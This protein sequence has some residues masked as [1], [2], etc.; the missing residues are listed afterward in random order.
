LILKITLF[1]AY[2]FSPLKKINKK[3][4]ITRS[5]NNKATEERMREQIIFQ[6]AMAQIDLEATL[7]SIRSYFL[8]MIANED[9]D[10]DSE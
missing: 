2:K 1:L 9:L 6:E 5:T 3:G 4:G 8:E 10:T 7:A